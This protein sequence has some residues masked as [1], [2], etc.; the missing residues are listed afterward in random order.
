M[1]E[2]RQQ[3]RTRTDVERPQQTHRERKQIEIGGR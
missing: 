1:P 3:N 2:N